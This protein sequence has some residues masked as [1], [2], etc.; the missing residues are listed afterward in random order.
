MI[1]IYGEILGKTD[2]TA[3]TYIVKLNSFSWVESEW[4]KERVKNPQDVKKYEFKV[5]QIT[6]GF[7]TLFIFLNSIATLNNLAVDWKE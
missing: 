6:I 7:F 4:E 1:S 3:L 5:E 2:Q